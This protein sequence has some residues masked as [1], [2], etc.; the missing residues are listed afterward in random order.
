MFSFL[1]KHLKLFT[2]LKISSIT[3][4]Q[5]KM[6]TLINKKTLQNYLEKKI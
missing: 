4:Q 2:V 1:K 5:F 3:T 6:K